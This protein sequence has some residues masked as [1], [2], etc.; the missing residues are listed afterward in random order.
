MKEIEVDKKERVMIVDD[1][2]FCLSSMKAIMLQ[3]GLDVKRKVDECI[4][5]LEALNQL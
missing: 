4:T 5:G 2:E 3:A 1:E